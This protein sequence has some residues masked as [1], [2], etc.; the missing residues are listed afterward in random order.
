MMPQ[1]EP[2]TPWSSFYVTTCVFLDIVYSISLMLYYYLYSYFQASATVFVCTT[3]Y[4][5]NSIIN[6]FTIIPRLHTLHTSHLWKY[7]K[8][9]SALSAGGGCIVQD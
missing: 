2:S 5:I 4:I 6:I 7:Q 3:L 8:N 9:S 1:S